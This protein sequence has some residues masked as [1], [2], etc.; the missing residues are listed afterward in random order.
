MRPM[1]RR[2]LFSTD[3][4]DVLEP[5]AH[6]LRLS[7]SLDDDEGLQAALE[8]ELLELSSSGEPLGPIGTSKASDSNSLEIGK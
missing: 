2:R 7:Q 1:T 5:S 4:Y 8:Q 6:A 3:D